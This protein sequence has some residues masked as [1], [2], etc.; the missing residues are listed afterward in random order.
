[1]K[2]IRSSETSVNLYRTT[3]RHIPEDGTIIAAALRPSHLDGSN[4]NRN[5]HVTAEL[6]CEATNC[7][8]VFEGKWSTNVCNKETAHL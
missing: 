6:L 1:M 3:L 4:D 2:V 7:L 5:A 8:Y